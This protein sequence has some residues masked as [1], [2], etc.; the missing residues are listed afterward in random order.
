[1][2][3]DVQRLWKDRQPKNQLIKFVS[4]ISSCEKN[5]DLSVS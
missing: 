2:N 3:R 1:M 4:L 5:V